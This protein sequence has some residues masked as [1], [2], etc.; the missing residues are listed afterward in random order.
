VLSRL[1]SERVETS[2]LRTNIGISMEQ[3]QR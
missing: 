3:G 1:A 2:P